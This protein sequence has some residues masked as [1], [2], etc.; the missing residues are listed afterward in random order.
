MLIYNQWGGFTFQQKPPMNIY[1]VIL[2]E[3]KHEHAYRYKNHIFSKH[4]IH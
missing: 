3:I 1:C 4:L 2:R